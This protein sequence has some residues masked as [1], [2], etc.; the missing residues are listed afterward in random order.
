MLLRSR[1]IARTYALALYV[2]SA[3]TT[4]AG[5]SHAREEGLRWTHPRSDVQRFEGCCGVEYVS[6]AA[7]FVADRSQECFFSSRALS[8][9]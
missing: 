1:T 7:V 8:S 4:G 3:L 6:L 2:L 5:L 9:Y